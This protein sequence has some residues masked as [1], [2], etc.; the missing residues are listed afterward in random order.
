MSQFAWTPTPVMMSAPTARSYRTRY[1][2]RR[3]AGGRS[4]YIKRKYGLSN[5]LNKQFPWS[6]FARMY[7]PRGTATERY[8]TSWRGA[9]DEQK[10][11]RRS[12]HFFGRGMYQ[13]AGMYQGS[14][15]F[16]LRRA[17]GKAQR[18][19]K[20]HR[21]GQTAANMAGY[22]A[23]YRAGRK[24]LGSGAYSHANDLFDHGTVDST[25]QVTTVD[26][27]TG[28]MVIT[29]TEYVGEVYGNERLDP[30]GTGSND[31]TVPFQSNKLILN[32]G[33]E[34]T[35]PW[36]SQIAANYQEYEFDQLVFKYTPQLAEVSSNN[37][38]VGEVLVV[39]QYKPQS[40]EFKSKADVMNYN[41]YT[42]VRSVDEGLHGVECDQSKLP[43]QK[44][45]MFVR[46]GGLSKD[47]SINDFDWGFTQVCVHNTPA[48]LA[49]ASIGSLEVYYTVKLSKPIIR[50]SKGLS[51]STSHS[52]TGLLDAQFDAGSMPNLTSL[53]QAK[54]NNS[55]IQPK[56]EKVVIAGGTTGTLPLSIQ[57]TYSRSL[58]DA[59]MVKLLPTF[60]NAVPAYVLRL[61]RT[62]DRNGFKITFPASYQG[63]VKLRISIQNSRGSVMPTAQNAFNDAVNVWRWLPLVDEDCNVKLI[64]DKDLH[65]HGQILTGALT[66]P[67]VVAEGPYCGGLVPL[68]ERTFGF[69]E[70][71]IHLSVSPAVNRLENTIDI[72]PVIYGHSSGN[73]QCYLFDNSSNISADSV[74]F[75]LSEYN[76]EFGVSDDYI[77]D[78]RILYVDK[79]GV[80][81]YDDDF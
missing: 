63:F 48:S 3:R 26:D 9:D 32:P 28:D 73:A 69:S 12:D 22:G 18:I 64:E 53:L 27:E 14:G 39:T 2:P 67:N 10:A 19:A 34:K 5:R 54:L 71:E 70:S 72:Y 30:A 11:N 76:P 36:L 29:H 41:H 47:E 50:S 75:H 56:I 6:S 15:K 21:L 24:I 1:T 4:A 40:T 79:K 44:E 65:A 31:P 81:G 23:E 43:L 61:N 77:T 35:F 74:S 68:A 33:M 16:K 8:G 45:T 20:K 78:P 59:M 66:D 49:N 60:P 80:T 42:K 58:I 51:V 62:Q 46:S 57:D 52:T 38:Q 17:L 55:A 13:G 7:V 37:G 25:P